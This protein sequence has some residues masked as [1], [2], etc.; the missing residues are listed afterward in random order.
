[1]LRAAPAIRHFDCDP[2]Q[3]RRGHLV[4]LLRGY[5]PRHRPANVGKERIRRLQLGSK[6]FLA[7]LLN[8]DAHTLDALGR[9]AERDRKVTRIKMQQPSFEALRIALRDSDSRVRIEDH[10]PPTVP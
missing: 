4:Y 3:Q 5:R 7:R 2:E 1:M 6:Q 9:N 10:I 8:S